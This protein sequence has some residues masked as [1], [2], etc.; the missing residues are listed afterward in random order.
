MPDTIDPRDVPDLQRVGLRYLTAEERRELCELRARLFV[1]AATP[2]APPRA[3]P[4]GDEYGS[5]T[6]FDVV[7]PG[8]W[9]DEPRR[10]A[11]RHTGPRAEQARAISRRL[12]DA[13]SGARIGPFI[14]GRVTTSGGH[15]AWSLDF[16]YGDQMPLGDGS[17]GAEG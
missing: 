15:D 7:S 2:V 13:P 3:G 5:Q 12:A 16:H 1:I 6:V 14:L 10:L 9:N 17:E 11:L 4:A 8:R